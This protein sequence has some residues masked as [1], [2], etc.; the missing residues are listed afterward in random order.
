MSNPEPGSAPAPDAAP[1]SV[2]PAGGQ[3]AT[4]VPAPAPN[5][6]EYDPRSFGA[7]VSKAKAEAAKELAELRSK[8]SQVE[9]ATKTGDQIRAERDALLG[10]VDTFKQREQK[11]LEA[12]KADAAQRMKDWDANAVALVGLDGVSDADELRA[13]LDRVS[14]LI[15]RATPPSVPGG[16]VAPAGLAAIDLSELAQARRRGIAYEVRAVLERLYKAHGRQAVDSAV[17]A[18]GR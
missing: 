9:D 18:Q 14:A 2:L 10:Q 13:R 11:R 7:G 12:A 17:T 8:L 15:Q 4:G 5:A 3:P 1:K 6:G 16:N